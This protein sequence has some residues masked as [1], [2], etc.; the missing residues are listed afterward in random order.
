MKSRKNLLVP[1]VVSLFLFFNI[2]VSFAVTFGHSSVADFDNLTSSELNAIETK[3]NGNST[4]FG[5]QSVGYNI[6]S[7]LSDLSTSHGLS[8]TIT[9]IT[10]GS[11]GNPTSKIN[12]FSNAVSTTYDCAFFKFCYVDVD[13]ST[14]A[15]A[16]FAQYQTAMNALKVQYPSVSFVHVTIPLRLSSYTTTNAIR[17]QYNDLLR[18]AYNG[19]SDYVY[20]LAEIE[21]TDPN[22]NKYTYLLSQYSL[23]DSHLNATGRVRAAKAFVMLL[24]TVYPN[25][26][27][28]QR[29]TWGTNPWT[30]NSKGFPATGTLERPY[31]VNYT[32]KYDSVQDDYALSFPKN[33]NPSQSYA[34]AIKFLPFYGS[35]TGLYHDTFASN[36]CDS[37]NVIYVGFRA[38]GGDSWLGDNPGSVDYGPN[39]RNDLKELMS[40]LCS[41]FNVKYFVPT[42]AS[43]GGHS[44]IR[45]A[46]DV[47]SNYIGAVVASCPAVFYRTGPTV[48]NP[49]QA[50]QQLIVNRIGQGWL[51]DTLVFLFHGTADTTLPLSDST[52]LY[53]ST[54]NHNWWKYYQL[55]G[56]G[57]SDFFMVESGGGTIENWG[58]S[59]L[60]SYGSTST[61]LG[62]TT[63]SDF[64][65]QSIVW[66]EL[67]AYET[68][69]PTMAS[70]KLTPLA[71]WTQPTNTSDWY[72]PKDLVDWAMTQTPDT[73][74]PQL[75]SITSGSVTHNSATIT[76]TT[77]ESADSTVEY[78]TSTSYGSTQN[79]TSL[80][81]SHS[82]SLSGL[83]P[84]TTYHYRVISDDASSNTATSTDYTFTTTTAP[85]PDTT[86]PVISSV[87][88]SSI[89]HNS[90]TITWT[91]NEAADSV[92]VYG[93]TT[94]YGST[95]SS[96]TL[97]TS[98]SIVLSGLTAQTT[99]HYQV[100]STDAS[101][102]KATSIDYTFTTTQAPPPGQSVTKK[103]GEN[104]TDDYNNVTKDSIVLSYVD[105][106]EVNRLWVRQSPLQYG[107]LYFDLSS[108][109]SSTVS[110]ATLTLKVHADWCTGGSSYNI[111][112]YSIEDPDS[113]GMWNEN[114]ITTGHRD[115][116]QSTTWTNSGSILTAISAQPVG[117]VALNG[118]YD[119][120][121]T[122]TVDITSIVSQWVSGAKTNHGLF[123]QASNGVNVQIY[124]RETAGMA[125]NGDF[126]PE[127]PSLEITY[128]S[129]TPPQN[130][131]PTANAGANQSINEGTTV[132]LDGSG[133]SDPDSDPLT[134]SWTQ[135]SGPTVTLSSTTAQKPTFTAPSV[136][137]NTNLVF[138]LT[139]NDGTVSSSADTVTI[140]VQDVLVGNQAPTAD[141]GSNQ[142]INEGLTVTLDGSGSSDPDSDPLTY[143]WTQTSGTTV[144][145]SSTTAEK[146][147]FTAPS[148]T[149]NTN[150]VFS[151][152]V[153]DG[154]VSSAA[155]TVTITVQDTS[156]TTAPSNYVIDWVEDLPLAS[157]TK[158]TA[159]SVPTGSL[160]S[161]GVSFIDSSSGH[162][163]TRISD[164][165]DHS[166]FSSLNGS[167]G[168]GL[169]N[170]YSRFANANYTEEYVLAY[171]TDQPILMYRMSDGSAIGLI[172]HDNTG[173]HPICELHDPRWDMSG[174]AGTEYTVYYNYDDSIY[175]MDLKQGYQ[176]RQLIY[177]FNESILSE[178]HMDQD[179]NA[180]Y[181]AIRFSNRI[182]VLDI[183]QKQI[184][185]G[186]VT[187]A[188]GG[189]DIS[190]EGDWLYA[191]GFGASGTET[192]F[193]KISDLAIGNVSSYV[194]LP[195][196][197]HG[198]DG[199]A[200]DAS[201]NEVYIFQDNTNDWFSAFNPAT[202]QRINILNMQET[203]WN[204]G[205]HMGRIYDSTKTGWLIMSSYVNN[206]NS[207][208]YNQLMMIEIK[209]YSATPKPRIWRLGHTYNTYSQSYVF[210]GYF[211]E[212]FGNLS[213]SGNTV[214][215]G[216]NWMG[217]DNLELYKLELP[218]N[219]HTVLNGGAPSNNPPVLAS[220]GSKTVAENSA[221]TF[222]A[223]A[224][225]ADGDTLTYSASGLPTG[226]TFNVTT[227]VFSW[228]PGYSTAGT[229]N[230][231]IIVTDG[232]LSDSETV[233]ITVTNTNR[234]PVLSAIGSKTVAENSALTFTASAT[235]A[236]GD[237]LTY[238]ATGLPTGAAFNVTTR[239]FSWTPG[240]S[241]AGTYNV[242]ISATDGSL[243]DSETV[244]ITVTNTNRAPVLSAIG[245]QTVAENSA[246]TFTA[247]ATD[248]DGDT[249]TYSASGLPTGATFN[250]TTRVFS[251]TPGY[252]TAGTYNVTIIV[253][254]GSLSDSE[255]VAITVTNKNLLPVANAGPDQIVVGNEGDVKLEVILDGSASRDEDGTIAS[256]IWKENNVQIAQGVKPKVNLVVG[257]HI[258]QLTV[259]DNT[260]AVSIDTVKVTV[261]KKV[262]E[263][264]NGIYKDKMTVMVY[265]K[266]LNDNEDSYS[267]LAER[268]SEKEDIG[269]VLLNVNA[270]KLRYD[271]YSKNVRAFISAMHKE[272]IFV[273]AVFL[274]S[275]KMLD[276]LRAIANRTQKLIAFQN[277][278]SNVEKFDGV[279]IDIAPESMA[280]WNNNVGARYDLVKKLISVMDAVKD[281]LIEAN[282]SVPFS[283]VVSADFM[284]DGLLQSY[285]TQDG[286]SIGS[287]DD[288]LSLCDFIMLKSYDDDAS[289]VIDIV[290][291]E[292]QSANKSNSILV[293]LKT[294]KKD[295]DD[296][297]FWQEGYNALVAAN[298]K[299]KTQFKADS[300]FLGTGV[301]EYESYRKLVEQSQYTNI[302]ITVGS[303]FDVEPATVW[304]LA[305][306]CTREGFDTYVLIQNAADE[307]AIVEVTF[308][309]QLSNKSINNISVPARSRKTLYVNELFKDRDVSTKV[310]SLNEVPL[311]V[312][313]AV[314]LKSN[315]EWI[316]GHNTIGVTE[317]STTWY[318]AEGNTG[319]FDTFVL[320]QNPSLEDSRVKVTFMDEEDNIVEKYLV[321]EQESRKTLHMN[322]FMKDANVSTKVESMNGVGLVVERSMYWSDTADW[323]GNGNTWTGA[324]A[325]VAVTKPEFKWFFAEGC[326]RGFDAFILLQN[327]N[328]NIAI[329]KLTLM[330]N[331]G[332]NYEKTYTLD[333]E[334]RKTIYVNDLL[335]ESDFSTK[336]ESLN[337]IPIIAERAMYWSATADRGNSGL[338][339][340]G[341]HVTI[342]LSKTST[343]LCLAEGCTNGFDEY[344]LIQNPQ[345]KDAEII[346][347]FMDSERNNIDEEI[348]VP[349]RSRYTI[350]VN[351]VMPN[352][353][354]SIEIRSTNGVEVIAERS[355]YWSKDGKWIGGHTSCA[356][357][358]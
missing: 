100:Q 200:Y 243:S 325:T 212:A 29:A 68:A 294:K 232:S 22:G 230:V 354:V 7:G 276:N 122:T 154:T 284:K 71:G 171:S 214:Y 303:I 208:A 158:K 65:D 271:G 351:K 250:V 53:N 203:G 97:A 79:N 48:W 116:S 109:A 89:T 311:V 188:N 151:L 175:S 164:V 12:A 179:K 186:V 98:H 290:K 178:D 238:S 336:V 124:S 50:V 66:S 44:A 77:N 248:A 206:N 108:I 173:N 297:T 80:V 291:D 215:W 342:G 81:T 349:A 73:T 123:L 159:F 259:I 283:A 27:P 347:S 47:P 142:S 229:Y 99:Y 113:K 264:V 267:A 318:L 352:R 275:E 10:V 239:V 2:S 234:A 190:T 262:I 23:D 346:V 330:D 163:I 5:H 269:A 127:A 260:G 1:L 75:S 210:S 204:F 129:G 70:Q 95:Q 246:L 84:Q 195:C 101:T 25:S 213:A 131:P 139:V 146:P 119:M 323:P 198:H 240:Y 196:T 132:T 187:V 35:G 288:F 20:D 295:D 28:T 219:W 253:T 170:G 45:I 64:T 141:A 54:T 55:Q 136:T 309:D 233:A 272:G 251:W 306:G 148:V 78:G 353:E 194:V 326:T 107:V 258:I 174:A 270:F 185:Q 31:L 121:Y 88:S 308:M 241:S 82:I 172:Q 287:P 180:K 278:S 112:L 224:T 93:T 316:C 147:T 231:T 94:S 155:D 37:N 211:A 358:N 268:M 207:W 263:K 266:T 328:K 256:Y 273:H 257:E 357:L 321:L 32:S 135:T 160:P 26:F 298:V 92:V 227:R 110:K 167:P 327:P 41:L 104:S 21:S 282:M 39:I 261:K 223:S 242:T 117:Q 199:W 252:S 343:Q 345:Y 13:S 114:S 285:L 152:T 222:T 11:N 225:D 168:E 177:D 130:N 218:S 49:D 24:N 128:S 106:S 103:W 237:S 19:T 312:E 299:V 235:D 156:Q 265:A 317:P 6:L 43:M 16:L 320:L 14:N 205:Q 74:P 162:R 334:S 60:S 30:S 4:L 344:L 300:A 51:N 292:I 63:S 38:R 183:K 255:T 91:T 134:Y 61:V 337:S 87:Q 226:A 126:Q 335:E 181:R 46:T 307:D 338:T 324:H 209:S 72:L 33:F 302:D 315:G 356:Y 42:G 350:H 192:R 3:I 281:E 319:G 182:V 118:N 165:G 249:L 18:A 348:I 176:S 310:V 9:D 216:A 69:N 254:D 96:S 62:R 150:L 76:W 102:N 314:Y 138:S 169:H 166:G 143:S 279:M 145:L 144:T 191:Q 120:N 105:S 332:E 202:S 236:D 153:N 83:I 339:W 197:N 322:Q 305:E 90:A 40:E 304:Y 286:K 58:V 86:P 52:T 221:L 245:S 17:K 341:G 228:T 293:S 67:S 280:S 313:R 296:T 274:R 193:Y 220:I 289:D 111:S 355:M 56:G 8:L 301:Y 125:N 59:D 57:H 244:A 331:F 217:T 115:Y 34:V 277:K 85:V 329:A 133:S 157:T 140:A 161:Q 340:V 36:Y 201:G 184:L 247:S 149:Q 137:Q 189:C 333:P 15:T